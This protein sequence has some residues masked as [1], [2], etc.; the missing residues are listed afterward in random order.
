LVGPA[1]TT[2]DT[3]HVKAN[4]A[5][6]AILGTTTVTVTI[7]AA[8]RF[9]L[10]DGTI[11][12]GSTGNFTITSQQ[13]SSGTFNLNSAATIFMGSRVKHRLILLY[14]ITGSGN[15]SI[16]WTTGPF[17]IQ[18]AMLRRVDNAGTGTIRQISGNATG[19]MRFFGC[20]WQFEKNIFTSPHQ[21]T[22]NGY[23]SDILVVD[24]DF[25]WTNLA[26][27]PGAVSSSVDDTPENSV[28][29]LLNCRATGA[30]PT[31]FGACNSPGSKKIARNMAGFSVGTALVGYLGSNADATRVERGYAILQS[32][33]ANRDF[34]I[35]NNCAVVDW[36]AGQGYPTLDAYLPSGLLWSYRAL[37]S[38]NV[39]AVRPFDNPELLALTKTHVSASAV[40]TITME[41]LLPDTSVAGITKDH[42]AMALTYVDSTGVTRTECSSTAPIPS[43]SA[44]LL[45]TSTAA[46]TLNS[47]GTHVPRKISITT[48]YPVKQNTEIEASLLAKIPAASLVDLFVNPEVGI[49]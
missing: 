30:T 12:A 10:D 35:E 7:T 47:Y 16:S 14:E 45:D 15:Y 31:I 38:S 23:I 17:Y 43:G 46:W 36:M 22:V 42:I 18:N 2:S 32:V 20:K 4:D 27:S 11:W 29:E 33:G 13:S 3:V 26:V 34:R 37:Y 6:I 44:P 28:F 40:R 21:I 48:A 24:C 5:V 9:L 25:V 1:L 39:N 8:M 19:Q 41:L 49:V